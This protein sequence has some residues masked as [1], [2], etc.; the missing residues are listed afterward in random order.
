MANK[1][2]SAN[3]EIRQAL[4]ARML[5]Q[6][7]LADVLGIHEETLSRKLRRELPD[8][9]KKEMLDAINQIKEATT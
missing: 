6:W 3:K 9:K 2:L 1:Q 4:A 5:S 7:Q 8:D